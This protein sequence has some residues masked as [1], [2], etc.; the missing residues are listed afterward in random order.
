[1]L[2]SIFLFIC[3]HLFF[4]LIHLNVSPPRST[5]F[6]SLILTSLSSFP[7]LPYRSQSLQHTPHSQ[8]KSLWNFPQGEATWVCFYDVGNGLVSEEL[9]SSQH[10]GKEMAEPFGRYTFSSQ[11]RMFFRRLDWFYCPGTGSNCH[12]ATLL[13]EQYQATKDRWQGLF[14]FH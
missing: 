12:W 4:H 7:P 1:M 3:S 9:I 2:Y 14:D 10:Y 8:K 6:V 13:I 11:H 5:H